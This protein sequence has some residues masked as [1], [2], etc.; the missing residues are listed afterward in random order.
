MCRTRRAMT[1]IRAVLNKY[2]AAMIGAWER[3]PPC[4]DSDMCGTE[5]T[6]AHTST[7]LYGIAAIESPQNEHVLCFPVGSTVALEL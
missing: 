1:P 7:G 4:Q 5:F 6:A 3:A 2:K